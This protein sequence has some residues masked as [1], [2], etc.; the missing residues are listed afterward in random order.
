M[1]ILYTAAPALLSIGEPVRLT[2]AAG[3][4]SV[5]VTCTGGNLVGSFAP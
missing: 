1:F 3:G 5:A 2:D 4:V